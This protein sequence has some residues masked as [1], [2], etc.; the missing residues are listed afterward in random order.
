MATHKYLAGTCDDIV[1]YLGR[2]F[3]RVLYVWHDFADSPNRRSFCQR[4]LGPA[5]VKTWLSRDYHNMPE[6]L[7]LLKD[8]IFTLRMVLRSAETWDIYIGA[9][10]FDAIPGIILKKLNRVRKTVFWAGD[11][12]P[13]AR[14]S[15]GWKNAVYFRVNRFALKSC[16]YAWNISPRVEM[17]RH[18]MYRL[19][20]TPPQRVVPIGVWTARRIRLPLKEIHRHRVV[21]VGNLLEKMGVQLA[22]RAIPEIRKSIGDFELLIIGKGVYEPRL[23]EI[24]RELGIEDFVIFAGFIPS[25]EEMEQACSRCA[26]AIAPYDAA[27]DIWTRYADPSKIKTYL[28]SGLPVIMTDVPFNAS[29]IVSRRCGAVIKYDAHD[30]A[31]AV[32][33]LLSNESLLEEYRRNAFE[34]S[35]QFDWN[36]ILD[37]AIADLLGGSS[38]GSAGK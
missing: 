25:D 26:C 18:A 7:V 20:S 24:V 16:D 9:S 3:S 29:E 22:L 33:S 21:F 17:A 30:F 5:I 32:V 34:Y 27:T 38:G 4:R 6:A 28:A 31:R 10:G 36:T 12:V 19:K 13:E 23:R 11:F 14:F 1:T 2:R 35:K 15:D 37:G 8:W